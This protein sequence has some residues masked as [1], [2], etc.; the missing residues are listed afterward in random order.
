M[1][2]QQLILAIE[3]VADG[4]HAAVFTDP[5]LGAALAAADDDC[6][7]ENV[8]GGTGA[9]DREDLRRY[10][11]E[12]V[13]PHRPADLTFRR[14]SRTANQRRVVDEIMIGFTHD[15]AL[16]WLLPGVEPTHRHAEVL[17]ISVIT[18]RHTT[19]LGRTASRITTHRTLWDQAGLLAQLQLTPAT[20]HI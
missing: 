8:P 7:L 20:T 13:L 18:F 5:D 12:D 19:N 3:R 17:A 6:V 11:A 14:L 16:P 15:T 2:I 9:R 10:L 1:G 4:F